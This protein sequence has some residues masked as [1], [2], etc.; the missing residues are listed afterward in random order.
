M[1]PH[2]AKSRGPRAIRAA[3]G[4]RLSRRAPSRESVTSRRELAVAVKRG[5]GR[6]H[7]RGELSALEITQLVPD[8]I[9]SLRMATVP[10]A[11][12]VTRNHRE[13]NFVKLRGET[14][15]VRFL[16]VCEKCSR[17][18]SCEYIGLFE[19]LAGGDSRSVAR[20]ASERASRPL[21]R[22]PR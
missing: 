4:H 17:P 18:A 2:Q 12:T 1:P 11:V 22:L 8:S 20:T 5:N 15:D 7:P 3:P 16:L 19:A 13:T 21:E 14:R 6:R 10:L 9:P